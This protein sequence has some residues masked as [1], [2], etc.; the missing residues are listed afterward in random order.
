MRAS[1]EESLFNGVWHEPPDRAANQQPPAVQRLATSHG[2]R[3]FE[4]HLVTAGMTLSDAVLNIAPLDARALRYRLPTFSR[5][6]RL[7]DG[8]EWLEW[9]RHVSAAS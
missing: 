1:D 3:N 7:A 2:L 9:K 4:L 6:V 8:A 5:R